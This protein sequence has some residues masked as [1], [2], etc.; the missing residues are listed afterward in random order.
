MVLVVAVVESV[1]ID[2]AH[3][4]CGEFFGGGVVIVIVKERG[5]L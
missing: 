2:M 3:G 4:K 5:L 1:G